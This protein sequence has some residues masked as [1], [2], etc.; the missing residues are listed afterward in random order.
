MGAGGVEGIPR[1]SKSSAVPHCQGLPGS[2]GALSVV[3]TASLAWNGTCH[4]ARNFLKFPFSRCQGGV[5]DG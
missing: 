4:P 5:L 1:R 3:S 2:P